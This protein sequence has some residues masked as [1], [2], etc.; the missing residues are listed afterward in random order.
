[1]PPTIDSVPRKLGLVLVGLESRPVARAL[2]E[3]AL[4]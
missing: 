4:P 3:P 2:I 1:V